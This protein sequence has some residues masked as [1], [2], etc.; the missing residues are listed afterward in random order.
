VTTSLANTWADSR[1]RTKSVTYNCKTYDS[2][3][4]FIRG[5]MWR[6]VVSLKNKASNNDL[7]WSSQIV[8]CTSSYKE[9]TCPP[10]TKCSNDECTKC[11][12]L[13]R[14]R[15]L[16]SNTGKSL[17][18]KWLLNNRNKWDNAILSLIVVSR[19]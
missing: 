17:L 18:K 19:F 1:S 8:K 14:K 7:V 13:P 10:F 2:E 5:C 15:S 16:P 9:P 4:Q 12:N 3:K 11:E 6:L